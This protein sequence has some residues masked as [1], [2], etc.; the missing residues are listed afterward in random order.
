MSD[1]AEETVE[2]QWEREQAL[3]RAEDAAAAAEARAQS[4][5]GRF[6]LGTDGAAGGGSDSV[7]PK[8]KRTVE[9]EVTVV[10]ERGYLVTKLERVEV[11][12]DEDD[13]DNSKS[14]AA[15]VEAKSAA[16]ASAGARATSRSTPA[17]PAAAPASAAKK[18]ALPVPAAEEK[19]E[20]KTKEKV[21]SKSIFSFMTK[22]E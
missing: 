11:S 9:R 13:S 7:A 12:D 4:T 17:A 10:N 16:D 20:R 14:A 18:P 1:E 5:L 21:V 3:A 6:I 8:R 2:Q 22:K 19:K 15:A